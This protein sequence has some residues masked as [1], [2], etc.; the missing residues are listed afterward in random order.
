M[1]DMAKLPAWDKLIDD[2]CTPLD[3]VLTL[4]KDLKEVQELFSGDLE[5]SEFK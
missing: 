2:M 3:S 5:D 4:E 1:D